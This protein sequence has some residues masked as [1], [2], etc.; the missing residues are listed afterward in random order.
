MLHVRANDAQLHVIPPLLIR[1]TST[2]PVIVKSSSLS[3]RYYIHGDWWY[4]IM[5]STLQRGIS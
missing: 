4:P 3:L 1:P 2:P 5:Q